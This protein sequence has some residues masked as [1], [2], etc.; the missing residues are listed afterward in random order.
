MLIKK[1]VAFL[2]DKNN[3]WLLKYIP[4]L[5]KLQKIKYKY[6]FFKSYKKIINYKIV[7]VLGFK[8]IL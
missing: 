6:N 7:F 1:K 4:L 3:S 2:L 5:K 8:R